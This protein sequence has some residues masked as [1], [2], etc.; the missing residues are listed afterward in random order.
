MEQPKV[1]RKINLDEAAAAANL[2]TKK[3]VRASRIRSLH[4]FFVKEFVG[5]MIIVIALSLGLSMIFYDDCINKWKDK[6]I[7]EVCKK[8][9]CQTISEI[10]EVGIYTET[11][12]SVTCDIEPCGKNKSLG[13]NYEKCSRKANLL[14]FIS[15]STSIIL[16]FKIYQRK[17]IQDQKCE[18]YIQEI[19]K[20]IKRAEYSVTELAELLIPFNHE[21]TEFHLFHQAIQT[22]RD[23][24]YLELNNVVFRETLN[25]E[26]IFQETLNA[27]WRKKPSEKEKISKA[28]SNTIKINLP[29]GPIDGKKGLVTEIMKRMDTVAKRKFKPAKVRV[30]DN[31]ESAVIE[32]KNS[33][34]TVAFY[35]HAIEQAFQM[36]MLD[37]EFVGVEEEEEETSSSSSASE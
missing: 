34:D 12:C 10:E 2:K 20:R 25:K 15:I 9:N 28:P 23:Y 11:V 30:E 16:I 22:I 31:K 32:F 21:Q 19:F 29:S 24:S 33:S 7:C 6:D 3:A 27:R 17:G 37:P 14:L 1:I 26:G 18:N 13:I 35:N 4:N 5:I 36:K 8:S